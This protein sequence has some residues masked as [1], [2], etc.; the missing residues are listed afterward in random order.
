MINAKYAKMMKDDGQTGITAIKRNILLHWGL[1]PPQY[2]VLRPIP[3]L[4]TSIHT[5][6]PPAFG[7]AGHDYFKSWKAIA[8]HDLLNES[9][10][11]L[12][13]ERL[14]KAVRRLRFF[15]HPDKLPR[16]LDEQQAFM[17]KML[18]DITNDSWEEHQTKTDELDWVN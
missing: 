5:V 12:D 18:W 3:V 9:N 8:P 7:V 6:F 11:N 2:Q 1:Q 4:I 13:D 17:A 14:K 10:N 16:D 15:L